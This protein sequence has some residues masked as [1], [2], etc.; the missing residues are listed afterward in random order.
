MLD[1]T[2]RATDFNL[3]RCDDIG[4]H[5]VRT[6][7][8]WRERFLEKL[9]LV[10]G[11]GFGERFIRMWEYYLSYCEAGFAERFIGTSQVVFARPGWRG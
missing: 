7:R 4:A 1:L 10:R 9:E 8:A 6:L 11:M 2:G 5:Y 3:V